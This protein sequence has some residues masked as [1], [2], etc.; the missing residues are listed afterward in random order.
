[1]KLFTTVAD[2][3]LAIERLLGGRRRVLAM[4][5]MAL[6]SS[7]AAVMAVDSLSMLFS[8]IEIGNC[9][10]RSVTWTL[11]KLAVFELI[12]VVALWL[13]KLIMNAES[14][15]AHRKLI[16]RCVASGMD[17]ALYGNELTTVA[18]KDVRTAAEDGLA[19]LECGCTWMVGIAAYML[20]GLMVNPAATAVL[21]IIELVAMI[22]MKGLNERLESEN[23]AR[24]VEYGKWFD[25]I[26]AIA[27]K[28]EACMACLNPDKL[29]RLLEKR[30]FHWNDESRR[31]LDTLLRIDGRFRAGRIISELVVIVSG[32]VMWRNGT[33]VIGTVYA[34]I[35][36]VQ[37]LCD[38]FEQTSDVLDD[39]TRCQSAIHRLEKLQNETFTDVVPA[40]ERID[41]SLVLSGIRFA[42]DGKAPVLEDVS[43]IFEPGQMYAITG[44]SGCGKS[45]LLKIM[46]GFLQAKGG[47]ILLNG[48]RCAD[49]TRDTLWS[50]VQYAAQPV[51][52]DGTFRDNVLFGLPMDSVM[53]ERACECC[54]ALL[55]RDKVE[56]C[57][58]RANGDPMSSGERQMVVI[59]RQI[60]RKSQVLLL[61]EPFSNVS[62]DVERAA[63]IQLKTQLPDACIIMATHRTEN[64]D[65]FD[66]VLTL[67]GGRL[68]E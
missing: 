63:L 15:I 58:I 56:G 27:D 20:Y 50:M 59:A 44:E 1:M 57:W 51:F 12:G 6:I 68:Y 49:M 48:Q 45:T 65:M 16:R 47:N 21:I 39:L 7:G 23:E 62:V 60:Y 36:T 43:M 37:K 54:A 41:G 38:L 28:M 40:H 42:Y 17:C 29:I 30:A 34:S 26:S 55:D 46:G 53:F 64:L 67:R 3:F 11:L 19:A 10:G 66:H 18:A 8:S 2:R 35:V 52:I 25:L 24:R 61:D 22:T 9:T 31:S 4:A 33:I 14:K 13:R 32:L 5:V